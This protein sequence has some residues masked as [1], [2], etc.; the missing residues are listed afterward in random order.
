MNAEEGTPLR[1]VTTQV[2]LP[3]AV[4]RVSIE[5]GVN[6]RVVGGSYLG[7]EDALARS[8]SHPVLLLDI[9]LDPAADGSLTELPAEFNGFVWMIEGSA[10]VGDGDSTGTAESTEAV[11]V[12]TGE[13]GLLFLPPGGDVL[14][15]RNSS[16]DER[17]RL[18]IGLGRPHRKPYFKYVGYGGGL[19]HRSLQEVEAS[20]SEYEAD[21]KNFG[22]EPAADKAKEVDMSKYV[23]VSGFQSDG[24]P[25]MERP[26]EAKARFAYAKKDV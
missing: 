21:P 23:L 11:S 13:K 26:P 19:I 18:F 24:G 9:R 5:G 22:R 1:P 10:L 16:A 4:P 17:A 25:M 3:E 8:V 14:R 2:V 6:I 7:S 20:M 12:I 15:L